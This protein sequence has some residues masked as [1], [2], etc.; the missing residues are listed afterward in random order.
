M[1]M[2]ILF[3]A[4]ADSSHTRKWA[5]GLHERGIE[6]AIFSLRKSQSGWHF[7]YPAIR[8]YDKEAFSNPMFTKGSLSKLSYLKSSAAVKKAIEDF[9]P[10]ILHAHYATS[11]GL[12]GVRS[13]FHPLIISVWGSDVFEFPD[14]SFLHRMMVANN[15]KR[16]DAVFSTSN[17]M[18]EQVLKLV[19]RP[20]TVT[21]FGIDITTYSRKPEVP[22]FDSETK[23]IGTIKTLEKHYGIDVLINSFA[24]VKKKYS[25][26]LKLVIC[27]SGTQEQE[28]KL[29]AAQSGYNDDIVFT[30]AISQEEVPQYMNRFDVF[31]NLSRQE[32]FGVAVLE[33]MSCE[34]P[35]VVSSAPGL[36]EISANGDCA[37]MV[38]IDDVYASAEAMLKCIAD[39]N[40]ADGL[41][42]KGRQRVV[43]HYNWRN[44]LT[45]I[46]A[47]YTTISAPEGK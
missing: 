23:V 13:K 3:L 20:V 38:P 18:K 30:G 17:V 37:V 47:K 15:L 21:P 14:K 31:A 43:Q 39:G 35:V 2:R 1:G 26:K 5:V 34:V 42:S 22:L 41:R 27:G 44:N 24:L 19:D 6:V 46:I 7:A 32:S 16:A 9:K 28:L 25:G 8:I 4:D 36:A 10:T 12:L 29:L 40:Y 33:A 45:D 11:Y